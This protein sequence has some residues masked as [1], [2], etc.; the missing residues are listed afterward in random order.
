M[1][2]MILAAGRG[3]RL[4]PLTDHIPKPLVKVAGR[5][6]LLWHILRLKKAGIEEI[7]VNSAW[8]SQKIVEFLGDGSK[9][10]VNIT[11]SVEGAGG[12]ET[13]GGI[14]RA[15]SFFQGEPFLVVNGDTYMDA[16]YVQFLDHDV[17]SGQA[18]L[19]MTQNP[20]HNPQ[21]DF[22]M[23]DDGLLQKGPGFTFSG[24]AIYSPQI[25]ATM[26]ET[27]LPLRPVFEK[28][29]EKK[30]LKGQM[31]RGRWFD[32]GTLQR[33]DEAD[34]YARCCNMDQFSFGEHK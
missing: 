32:V 30:C 29:I 27:R 2:A 16:D 20:M 13:A 33:L 24:A 12:L 26:S 1:R 21:G 19:F 8:L 17:K 28:L 23:G 15:L 6:L 25:F 9:W 18:L 4:R 22:Y 3:E 34:A 7:V 11:H 5:E 31:L 10:N 14:I